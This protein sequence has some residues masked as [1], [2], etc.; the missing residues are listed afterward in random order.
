M[1]DLR[2]DSEYF[3]R[4]ARDGFDV[5]VYDEVGTGRSSRLVARYQS[6]TTNPPELIFSALVGDHG[7]RKVRFERAAHA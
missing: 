4:L 3:G 5:Y 6:R 2:G 1:P 7:A